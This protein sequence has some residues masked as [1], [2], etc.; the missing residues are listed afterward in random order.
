MDAVA[1]NAERVGV[2]HTWEGVVPLH[3]RPRPS[4]DGAT[5][6][7]PQDMAF[8]QEGALPATAGHPLAWLG[9]AQLNDLVS[10]AGRHAGLAR[11]VPRAPLVWVQDALGRSE[12][13]TIHARGLAGLGLDPSG[14]IAVRARRPVDALW[15]MEEALRA[16]LPVVGEVEGCPRALDFTATRRLEVRARAAGVA[17]WLVRV[18]PR[19]RTAGSSGARH[20]WRVLSHPSASDPHDP[21]APGRPR[22]TLELTRARDRP[23]GA[24]VVEAASDDGGTPGSGAPHRLRVVAELAGGGVAASA[25]AVE[26]GKGTVIPLRPGRAA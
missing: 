12:L 17:C 18:G 2:G 13:G 7:P 5:E 4:G 10:P 15:A 25:S 1:S 24:W 6:H 16:G 20:R 26:R 11:A 8:G 19:A 14:V 21:R 9:A 23:P 3:G 22:W